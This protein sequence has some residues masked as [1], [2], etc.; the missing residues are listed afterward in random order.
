[1]RS[2]IQNSNEQLQFYNNAFDLIRLYAAIQVFV[3]HYFLWYQI[4]LGEIGTRIFTAFPGVTVLFAGG[5]YL[6]A[7]S[8]DRSKSNFD[9]LSKRAIRLYPEFWLMVAV[10]LLV[11]FCVGYPY[12]VFTLDFIKWIVP[13][14]MGVCTTPSFFEGYSVGSFNGSLWT[15]MVEV[16]LYIVTLFLFPLAKKV[17]HRKWL[18][19]VSIFTAAEAMRLIFPTSRIILMLDRTFVTHATPYLLG[20]TLYVYKDVLLDKAKK[21]C[22]PMTMGYLMF[23]IVCPSDE[24]RKILSLWV[25]PVC[26]IG[27]AYKLGSIRLKFDVSYSIYLYHMVVLNVWIFFGIQ[28]GVVEFLLLTL[29]VGCVSVISGYVFSKV[30][31]V[32]SK[33][34][35]TYHNILPH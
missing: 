13:E 30:S 17:N 33:R 9:F 15:I 32:L 28:V 2:S 1:M 11:I 25:V 24:L 5:G 12:S 35:S 18:A 27:L 3:G 22:I 4:S 10:N 6:I 8:L 34:I 20:M 26:I 19:V 29:C 14:L 31:K 23:C 16:Q 7:A 21:I